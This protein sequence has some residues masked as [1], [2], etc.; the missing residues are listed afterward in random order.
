MWIT[1]SS[2]Q[3]VTTQK[4]INIMDPKKENSV[5]REDRETRERQELERQDLNDW[6][7]AAQRARQQG[8]PIP[9]EPPRR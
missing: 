9:P 8:L 5:K 7:A 3:Q 6:A 2:D 4:A 1:T